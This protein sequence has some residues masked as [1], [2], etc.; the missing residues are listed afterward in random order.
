LGPEIEEKGLLPVPGVKWNNIPGVLTKTLRDEKKASHT[1]YYFRMRG[2]TM[3]KKIA[4]PQNKQQ[5]LKKPTPP[6]RMG[7]LA[8]CGSR[9]GFIV[10]TR[11]SRDGKSHNQ[12]FER[13]SFVE[14]DGEILGHPPQLHLQST[15]VIVE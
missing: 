2:K 6:H 10:G 4:N 11:V 13:R 3:I 9:E 8:N 5:K 14:G 12:E 1:E 15:G 7:D